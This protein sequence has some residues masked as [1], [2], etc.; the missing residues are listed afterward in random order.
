MQFIKD[1]KNKS[2]KTL[3]M[4][5]GLYV[6]L[7]ILIAAII[8]KEPSFLS[9]RN[10]RNILT[11]SS[12]RTI[13]ALGVAGI[14]VTQGT[15][16]SVGRQVGLSAVISATL[17]QAMTNVNKVFPNL[18]TMSIPVVILV[19]VPSGDIV[20][21]VFGPWKIQSILEGL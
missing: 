8:I 11:Q 20:S 9:F 12:V 19:I 7:L 18:D 21:T 4:E 5:N 3:L 17:L 14:I 2:L 13:L 15:D 1:L 10:V 6:V 16:L